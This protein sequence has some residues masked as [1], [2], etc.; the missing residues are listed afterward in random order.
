MKYIYIII[1]LA[2]GFAVYM[3]L[4]VKQQL[5]QEATECLELYGNERQECLD[6]NIEKRKA[7]TDTQQN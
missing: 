3:S 5:N 1:V 6:E 2:I 7:I 4:G